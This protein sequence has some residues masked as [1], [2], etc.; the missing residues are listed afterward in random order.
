MFTC[1]IAFYFKKIFSEFV[2]LSCI[3]SCI[4][5]TEVHLFNALSLRVTYMFAEFKKFL[6]RVFILI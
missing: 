1:F 4:F 3:C 6:N 2:I 5:Q